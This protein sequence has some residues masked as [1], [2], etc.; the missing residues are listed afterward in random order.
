MNRRSFFATLA[1]GLAA[2]ADP[3]RLL[4]VPGKKMIS[5]PKPVHAGIV[6]IPRKYALAEVPWQNLYLFGPDGLWELGPPPRKLTRISRNLRIIGGVD[7]ADAEGVVIQ[8]TY[9]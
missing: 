9:R 8:E 1:A 3:E 2:A 6:W 5:I 4:W 7:L